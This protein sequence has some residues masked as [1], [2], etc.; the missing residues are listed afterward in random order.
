MKR[1]NLNIDDKKHAEFKS[2]TA[3]A[4]ATMADVLTAAID[5]YL[6]GKW[7]PKSAKS[8]GSKHNERS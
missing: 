3:A 2:K 1:I 6:A 4:S 8:K 7:R 5:D